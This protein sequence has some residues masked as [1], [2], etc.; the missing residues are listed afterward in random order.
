MNGQTTV[1]EFGRNMPQELIGVVALSAT[2]LGLAG[3]TYKLFGKV[4]ELAT[5]E[6]R[7][8]AAKWLRGEKDASVTTSIPRIFTNAFD[9]VFC[10]TTSVNL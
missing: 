5:K 10:S 3:G 4:D 1:S 8:G 6:A 2:Y 9:S 7:E